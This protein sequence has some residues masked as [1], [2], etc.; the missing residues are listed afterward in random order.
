MIKILL[1]NYL[2]LSLLISS[3]SF[4]E[5]YVKG[6][7]R[8]NGTYVESHYRS[9]PNKSKTDNWSTYGNTNPRTGKKGKK[10]K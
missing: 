8:K 6:H 1:K 4:A 2:L 9:D 10:K 7:Y 3:T 5:V